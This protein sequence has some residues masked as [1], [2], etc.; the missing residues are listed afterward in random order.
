MSRL[1]NAKTLPF[2]IKQE[3]RN[4]LAIHCGDIVMGEKSQGETSENQNNICVKVFH[5]SDGY[6][7][8]LDLFMTAKGHYE[9]AFNAIP[10]ENNRAGN[11]HRDGKNMYELKE[12]LHCEPSSRFIIFEDGF[13]RES[14]AQDKNG[15]VKG[16]N[17]TE[18]ARNG[19]ANY[20]MALAYWKQWPG[21][22][23]QLPNGKSLEDGLLHVRKKMFVKIPTMRTWSPIIA[24]K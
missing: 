17:I 20:K 6:S 22:N 1:S 23:K 14:I 10:I 7:S 15:K 13:D 19:V 4:L 11:D 16:R 8:I 9:C 24:R 18:R 5:G 2:A 12:I 21:P 3:I